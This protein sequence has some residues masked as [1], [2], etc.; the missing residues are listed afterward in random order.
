[1][2]ACLG[3][4]LAWIASENEDT[5]DAKY[6]KE[7]IL[8]LVAVIVLNWNGRKVLKNCLSSLVKTDYQN[9]KVILV[10]NAS[11]DSSER[12]G[13]EYGAD[14]VSLPTNQ[15]YAVG[16]NFG[17]R[18]ALE[19]YNPEYIVLLNNDTVLIE[20]S[21]LKHMVAVAE[22]DSNIGIVNCNYVNP[23][24]RPQKTGFMLIPGIYLPFGTNRA[25]Q[26]DYIHEAKTAGG[27]CY[28]I[29]RAVI[30]EVGFLDEGFSPFYFEDLDYCERARKAGFRLIHDGK[31][32][33]LHVGGFSTREYR[34]S[35]T[36]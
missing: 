11:T 36:T 16:N 10:D 25:E 9:M 7:E 18:F 20:P 13:L 30:D 29:K 21:W 31:V 22:S 23:D 27:P 8:K 26:S 1:M 19:K 17:I 14:L 28:L 12:I 34:E 32:T 3:Q 15:G 5:S 4:T 6:A 33:I 24:G 2:K 35:E